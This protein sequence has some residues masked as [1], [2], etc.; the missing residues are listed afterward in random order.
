MR[1]GQ[2][3]LPRDLSVE[4][5]AFQAVNEI[6]AYAGRFILQVDFES[7]VDELK[8]IYWRRYSRTI[9]NPCRD[10]LQENAVKIAKRCMCL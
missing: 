4:R 7:W 10:P 2:P 9:D 3:E 6:A 5:F 8:G 1:T